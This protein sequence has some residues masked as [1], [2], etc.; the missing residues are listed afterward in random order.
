M[1]GHGEVGGNE[2][3]IPKTTCKALTL[4]PSLT[5][6]RTLSHTHTHTHT[7][8]NTHTHARRHAHTQAPLH[9]SYT[10]IV[11]EKAGGAR[12]QFKVWGPLWACES[13]DSQAFECG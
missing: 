2:L 12:M 5:L 11:G 10:H 1:G 9:T 13:A 6:S 3:D 4:T 7:H 8:T